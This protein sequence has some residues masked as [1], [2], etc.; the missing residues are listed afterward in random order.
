M[1]I[2]ADSRTVSAAR[3]SC[4]HACNDAGYVQAALRQLFVA[5]GVVDDTIGNTHDVELQLRP[6]VTH[7]LDLDGDR[8]AEAVDDRAL[9]DAQHCVM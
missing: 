2:Q 4:A 5:A 3:A 7:R 6:V 9:F 8:G 1:T